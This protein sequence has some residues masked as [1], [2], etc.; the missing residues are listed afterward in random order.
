MEDIFVGR[1][2]SSPVETVSPDTEVHVAA[3]KMIDERIGSVL[4]TDDEGQLA[5]ILT[6][7]DFVHIAAEQ[8]WAADATVETYMTTDVTTTTA[9]AE[10]RDV[11]DTMIEQGFHHMPVVDETEGVVGIITTTDITAYMSHVQ[12]PSPS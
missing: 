9:N 11:A 10:I 3:E 2:M 5:G 6:A 8:R 12:T 7:T 4:V 1:L